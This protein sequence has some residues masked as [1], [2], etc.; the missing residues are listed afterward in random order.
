M[1]KPLNPI[2]KSEMIMAA[3]LLEM[4]SDCFSN[5]GCND[6]SLT[7]YYNEEEL[8]AFDKEM[9]DW[10]GDPEEHDPDC[11]DDIGYDWLMMTVMAQKLRTLAE[12]FNA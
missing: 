7:P 8:I 4:A 9:H 3:D 6:F 2:T 12:K 1:H 10:N 5:N 11:V